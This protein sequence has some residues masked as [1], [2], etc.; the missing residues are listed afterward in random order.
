MRKLIVAPAVAL[1]LT[2]LVTPLNAIAGNWVEDF[3]HPFVGLAV[4][5]D[6]N[7]EWGISVALQRHAAQSDGF[8]DRWALR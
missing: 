2:A 5:Y 1:I 3:E 8:S 6:A 4:F 7:G